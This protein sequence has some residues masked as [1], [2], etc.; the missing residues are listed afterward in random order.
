MY[1][2]IPEML[3]IHHTGSLC[4]FLVNCVLGCSEVGEEVSSRGGERRGR[5]TWTLG[6]VVAP[7]GD[8]A[9]SGRRCEYCA[10]E[11]L[12]DNSIWAQ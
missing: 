2:T 5:S 4:V 11:T 9:C 1:D 12:C 10:P 7:C 8:E 3:S 6:G